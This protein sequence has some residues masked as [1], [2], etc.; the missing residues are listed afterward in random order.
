[1]EQIYR[2][3]DGRIFENKGAAL[4][5][6]FFLNKGEEKFIKMV[7]E[8]LDYM[9]NEYSLEF[10]VIELKSYIDWDQDP[11][12]DI[13]NFSEYQEIEVEVFKDGK[14]VGEI[15]DRGSSNGG[16]NAETLKEGLIKEYV[17]P[18]LSVF[19]G[20]VEEDNDFYS[21]TAYRISDFSL[22]MIMPYLIGKKV[23]L[24]VLD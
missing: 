6:D 7:N 2:T 17:H 9:S 10:K 21:P 3:S 15:Y 16:W 22:E 12:S 5:H 13:R 11:N 24:E 23:K 18:Y 8:V 4:K 19:E 14:Q 20:I 1:M